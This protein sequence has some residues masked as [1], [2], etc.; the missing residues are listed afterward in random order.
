MALLF[1]ADTYQAD[2]VKGSFARILRRRAA[3]GNYAG[4]LGLKMVVQLQIGLDQGRSSARL[5]QFI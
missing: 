5:H 2:P 1:A 3:Q 4:V